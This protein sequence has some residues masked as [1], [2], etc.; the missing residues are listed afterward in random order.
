[1]LFSPFLI[2]TALALSLSV[3]YCLVIAVYLRAWDKTEDWSVPADF[4]PKTFLSVI[5]PVR[6]EANNILTCL[7][8]VLNQS[9]PED[10]YEVIVVDDHSEDHTFILV[11]SL[12]WKYKNLKIVN[13][14]RNNSDTLSGAF[15]KMALEK[16]ISMARG[17]LIVTTDA[18]CIAQFRWLELIASFYE[19]HNF[20]VLAAPVLFLGEKNF[21]ERFQS[22]DF[23]GWMGLTGGAITGNIHSMCNGANFCYTKE[24]YK[25]VDG[26]SGINKISSGDDIL[27]MQKIRA[28]YPSSAFFLRNPEAAVFTLPVSNLREFLMQRIR[29][30]SKS[31][32]YHEKPLLI[33]PMLVFGQCLMIL[34]LL[35]AIPFDL[36][37]APF[38]VVAMIILKSG[39]DY[40]LLRNLC[41]YYNKQYLL[42]YFVPAQAFYIPYVI[43]AGIGGLV[44]KRHRWKGRLIK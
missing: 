9:Y 25:A 32:Y 11:N 2:F 12:L 13:L 37:R 3:L 7:S 27:L 6:N 38:L 41:I 20:K 39:P 40:V 21:L 26:F 15:K 34:V 42:R 19:K 18:D 16:G 1:M 30:S 36:V 5:I 28:R 4:S 17:E 29:W 23:T 43:I 10:L 24:A 22:L 35:I 44:I 14:S 8:Y 31:S 33:I